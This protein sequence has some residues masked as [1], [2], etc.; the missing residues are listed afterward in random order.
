[1]FLFF[2]YKVAKILYKLYNLSNLYKHIAQKIYV[3][4]FVHE[5]IKENFSYLFYRDKENRDAKSR[6]TWEASR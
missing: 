6:R 4:N 1:M 5:Q 3:K 2:V